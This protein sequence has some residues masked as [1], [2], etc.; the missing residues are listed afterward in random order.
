MKDKHMI[1]CIT[2]LAIMVLILWKIVYKNGYKTTKNESSYLDG[3][4][5]MVPQWQDSY[6]QF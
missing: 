2:F 5:F 3:S 6:P 4:Y 1:F